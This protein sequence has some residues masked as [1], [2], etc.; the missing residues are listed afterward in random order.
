MLALMISEGTPLP[1]FELPTQFGTPFRPAMFRGRKNLLILGYPMDWTPVCSSEL[2]ELARRAGEF[3]AKADTFVVAMNCDHPASHQRWAE[4]LGG[5]P[6]PM[7]CDLHPHGQISRI[8]GMWLPD[9]SITDRATVIVDRDGIVRYATSVGKNGRRNFDE[10]L[11]EAV[12]ING[13]PKDPSAEPPKSPAPAA[14]GAKRGPAPAAQA[15]STGPTLFVLNGCPSCMTVKSKLSRNPNRDR[16][17]IVEVSSAESRKLMSKLVPGVTG[18]PVLY[19]P[20]RP[21]AVGAG[22]VLARINEL[23]R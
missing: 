20:G 8:L 23:T 1:D 9:E 18:V 14:A 16:I 6:Y 12:R 21:A 5:V 22:D 15:L 4:S 13:G 17:R 11:E 3:D 7:L 10:L 2:P 19:A